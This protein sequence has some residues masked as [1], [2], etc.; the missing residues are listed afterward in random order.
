MAVKKRSKNCSI[1]TKRGGRRAVSLFRGQGKLETLSLYVEHDSL[2][3]RVD[4]ISK[5]LYILAAVA[6]PIILPVL[7][8]ALMVL[9]ASIVVLLLGRILKKVIP[10]IS[11]I[12]FVLLTILVIQ[13]LFKAGNVTPLFGLGSLIFY[14]EGFY[15]ALGVSLRVINIMLAFA[16]LI[17]TTKASDLF[18][19]LVRR[20]LSPRIGYVLSSVLQIIPQMQNTVGTITDAQ[21]SRG[22]ETEGSLA[23]RVKAFF[24]LIG[25]VVMSSL[26]QT[27]ERSMALEVRGFSARVK[28]SFLSE[29]I[30]KPYHKFIQWGLVVLMVL[31]LVLR[32]AV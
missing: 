27:R 29:E 2:V 7:T 19:T 31:A 10:L 24:P 8:T 16:I 32:L 15:Y 17:L 5:L 12:V 22:L 14:K 30:R 1:I 23:V 18:E 20:G 9:L 3:H 26:S 25:P 6:I 4:P 13:G 21:R 11:V 28:K